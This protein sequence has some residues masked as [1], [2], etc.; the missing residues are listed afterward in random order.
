MEGE[1]KALNFGSVNFQIRQEYQD[2]FPTKAINNR[3]YTRWL[4]GWFYYDVGFRSH[5]RS[6]CRDIHYVRTTVVDMPGAQLASRV[7]L[8]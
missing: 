4:K 7:A 3:W 5:L 6:T 1:T 2:A 8:L